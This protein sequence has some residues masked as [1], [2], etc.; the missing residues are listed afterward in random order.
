MT[1]NRSIH[2][3]WHFVY[4]GF[5]G[6]ALWF[7]KSRQDTHHAWLSGISPV[8]DNMTLF[9][10]RECDH[11]YNSI[12]KTSLD[13]PSPESNSLKVDVSNLYHLAHL[14]SN[15]CAINAGYL[16]TLPAGVNLDSL[17]IYW[18]QFTHEVLRRSEKGV[19][20]HPSIQKM[21]APEVFES[22]K[23]LFVKGDTVEKKHLLGSLKRLLFSALL[24]VVNYNNQVLLD[25][26]AGNRAFD[27]LFVGVDT[28][29]PPV[30]GQPVRVTF[31]PVWYIADLKNTR[32]FIDDR[33][34]A[35]N[36][37]MVR[38]DTSYTTPGKKKI[39]VTLKNTT[40]ETGAMYIFNREYEIDFIK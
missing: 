10:A 19:F 5:I 30:A 17:T 7:G 35:I 14:A 9:L 2:P 27:H 16:D 26:L 1:V 31:S 25:K 21:L 29:H 40:P 36:Q 11:V 20:T 34:Y 28:D 37:G 8:N 18:Q 39:T 33:E 4:A 22:W 24:P 38:F 23:M 32:L 3:V 13:Y 6:G 12:C 15:Q